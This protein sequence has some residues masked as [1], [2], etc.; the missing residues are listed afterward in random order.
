[1]RS[2]LLLITSA[3]ALFTTSTGCPR[4]DD[5]PT[6]VAA[7]TPAPIMA[8]RAA[9]LQAP[10]PP[11]VATPPPT[12]TPASEVRVASVEEA[13]APTQAVDPATLTELPS[14]LVEDGS[15]DPPDPEPAPAKLAPRGHDAPLLASIAKETWVY[16]APFWKS[17]RIGYLRAGAIV[18]RRRAPAGRNGACPEGWYRIE[19]KGYVCVGMAATLNVAHPVVEAS[20]GRPSRE[21]L[22]YAYVMSRFPPPPFYARLPSAADLLRVEPDLKGHLRKSALMALDPSYVPPP[23]P[24]P[25]PSELQGGRAAPALANTF[26][27]HDAVEIGRARARSGFALLATFDHEGR[28]YGLTTELAVLPIDRTRVIKPSAFAGQRLDD[29]VTLPLAFVRSR[30]AS[31]FVAAPAGGLLAGPALGFRQA[32][33]LS[34]VEKR[35]GGVAYLEAKDGSLLRAEQAVQIDPV[36]RAP[37][38]AS[39]GRK[40]IDVS[41]LKQSLTAYEGTKPVYVTLVSTGADGLGDPKETHST[42]QGAFLIHTKHVSV[43]MDDDKVGD[44][45]DFR[46]VPFVQYF[47]EGFALHGAY[48]H[49]DFG[50]PRSHGCVNLSPTDA[51]WLFNWTDPEVPPTWHGALSIRKGTLVY[52][53]P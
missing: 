30:H 34:G 41:I 2:G 17:R 38:W 12:P 19:P 22:P 21:G 28:R 13:I 20:S 6:R 45:F 8:V 39:S 37:A 42:I 25:I 48:W 33:P 9:V 18:A 36:H 53:H 4:G 23:P 27:A 16:A 50:T 7:P 24:D 14:E 40:W 46:D 29:E 52:I 26:R 47:T 15:E 5:S 1:M 43:T 10:T 35:I 51:A 49:D 3:L 32:V 31:R 11:V 44:E